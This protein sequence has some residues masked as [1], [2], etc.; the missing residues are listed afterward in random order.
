MFNDISQAGGESD[1]F[2]LMLHRGSISLRSP[3]VSSEVKPSRMA[4]FVSSAT[5]W[6]FSFSMI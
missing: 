6:S 3:R 4:N 5:E 1:V 2:V